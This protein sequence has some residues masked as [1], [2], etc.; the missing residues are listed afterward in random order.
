MCVNGEVTPL[1]AYQCLK[2][3]VSWKRLTEPDRINL[4]AESECGR[5]AHPLLCLCV[6]AHMWV[7]FLCFGEDHMSPQL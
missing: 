4:G 1:Y 7:C 3:V 6:R 2:L 5:M